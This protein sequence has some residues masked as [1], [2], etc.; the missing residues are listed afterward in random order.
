MKRRTLDFLT[1]AGASS[2]RAAQKA[3]DPGLAAL[4]Q[5]L[6]TVTAQRETLFKG[7]TLRGLL[8]TFAPPEPAA[9]GAP[10]LATVGS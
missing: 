7:E 1:S 8:L 2:W 3:N 6:T 5:Q 9:H 10:A 4:H